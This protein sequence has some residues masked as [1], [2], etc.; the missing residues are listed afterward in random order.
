MKRANQTKAIIASVNDYL[1]ENHARQDDPVFIVVSYALM[2]AGVYHGFNFYD[3]EGKLNGNN[4][5]HV[6]LY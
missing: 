2:G 1:R 4:Y 3:S 5:D 6:Q